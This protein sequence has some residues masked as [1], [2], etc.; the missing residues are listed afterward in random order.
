MG[1]GSFKKSITKTA[2]T[3]YFSPAGGKLNYFLVSLDAGNEK[4]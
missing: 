1:D 2:E 4:S 3:N